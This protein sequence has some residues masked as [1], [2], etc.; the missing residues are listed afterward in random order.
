MRSAEGR[1]CPPMGRHEP[2]RRFIVR[3]R[4]TT[5]YDIT[6]AGLDAVEQMAAQGLAL[7][8]IAKGLNIN[9]DTFRL[10]R[11]RDPRVDEAI[12]RG[13]AAME[14]VLVSRLFR[15]AMGESK[16][17]T[18]A[19]IFLLKSR[20]GYENTK[21]PTHITINQ[22]NRSQTIALPS[23]QDMDSYLKRITDAEALP[24]SGEHP[25]DAE[26]R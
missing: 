18:T 25:S 13:G 14:D 9:A 15:T 22:D 8:T 12:E 10:L 11:K 5:T 7:H 4:G 19:A 1:G 26:D 6:K 24:V 17:A 2:V 16:S 20:R 21:V 3:R 23:A